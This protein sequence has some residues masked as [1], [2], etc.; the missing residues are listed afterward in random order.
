MGSTPE[1]ES[2][3]R[4]LPAKGSAG[5]GKLLG[6][7]CKER[8]EDGCGGLLDDGERLGEQLGVAGIEADVVGAGAAGVQTNGAADNEGHGLSFSLAYGLGGGGAALCA[9]QHLV[10]LCRAVHKRIYVG[11]RF[12]LRKDSERASLLGAVVLNTT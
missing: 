4:P 11:L 5:L 8:V 2:P 10:R 12:M 6:L 3:E 1:R 7:F 9:V